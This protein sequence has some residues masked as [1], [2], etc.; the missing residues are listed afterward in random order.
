MPDS[1]RFW[2]GRMNGVKSSTDSQ[3]IGAVFI[4][5]QRRGRDACYFKDVGCHTLLGEEAPCRGGD[6]PLQTQHLQFD[7]EV[8]NLTICIWFIWI[9]IGR[10]VRAQVRDH[11]RQLPATRPP[12][13]LLQDPYDQDA[14]DMPRPHRCPNRSE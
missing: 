7:P 9:L 8:K 13:V 4:L 2:D 11:R 12:V 3:T 14:V 5:S 1:P 6:R 10:K